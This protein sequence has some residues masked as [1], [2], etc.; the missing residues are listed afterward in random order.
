M[1]PGR[2]DNSI[3]NHWNS[4]M[5]KKVPDMMAT[6]QGKKQHIIDLLQKSKTNLLG[7]SKLEH[8]VK[9]EKQLLAIIYEN[10]QNLPSFQESS[11]QNQV[12]NHRTFGNTIQLTQNLTNH[13]ANSMEKKSKFHL[14]ISRHSPQ[15]QH[16]SNKAKSTAVFNRTLNAQLNSKSIQK[17]GDLSSP[18]CMSSFKKSQRSNIV[19]QNLGSLIFQ[20]PPKGKQSRNYL[21][22][23]LDEAN[24]LFE[25]RIQISPTPFKCDEEVH[26]QFVVNYVSPSKFIVS[27][28][29]YKN[30]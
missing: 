7:A 20:T 26:N 5:K 22:M 30:V 24:R 13:R 21:S 10:K 12:V 8:F 9:M 1:I 17:L 6:L 29:A 14:S 15:H 19:H 27:R 3:K 16:D 18:G 11:T 23:K 25:Q 4:T 2:T 28:S